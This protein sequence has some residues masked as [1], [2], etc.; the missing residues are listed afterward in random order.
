MSDDDKSLCSNVV[1]VLKNKQLLNCFYH[2][3]PRSAYLPV[4]AHTYQY[5][6]IKMIIC[7]HQ[8]GCT[9]EFVWFCDLQVMRVFYDTECSKMKRCYAYH[10]NLTTKAF[11]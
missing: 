7:N 4:S 9:R 8:T 11:T 1:D 2:K 5:W 3:T 10:L 6:K